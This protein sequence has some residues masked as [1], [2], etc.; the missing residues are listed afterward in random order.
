MNWINHNFF[1]PEFFYRRKS[2]IVDIFH[3][4]KILNES[5][6]QNNRGL[7]FNGGENSKVSIL[8]FLRK[9]MDDRNID[10]GPLDKALLSPG[11]IQTLG[12]KILN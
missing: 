7:N 6:L 12:G 10:W 3:H 8:I 4:C 11:C 5:I 1:D 2:Q 9:V